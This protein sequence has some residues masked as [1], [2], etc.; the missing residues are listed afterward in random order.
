M[1]GIE[2]IRAM[3]LGNFRR[4]AHVPEARNRTGAYP[5][6]ATAWISTIISGRFSAATV[7]KVLA[8]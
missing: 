7:T 8:G 1:R 2:F 6:T 3:R 5:S 4:R